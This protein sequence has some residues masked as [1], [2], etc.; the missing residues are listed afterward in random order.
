MDYP[1]KITVYCRKGSAGKTPI[2][3]NIALDRGYA[4]ATNE[5]DNILD[6]I[7][8]EERLITI[9][10]G[11][12]FPSFPAD[13]DIVFDLAGVLSREASPSIISAIEQS[14]VV[15]V[16]IYNELKCLNAGLSTIREVQPH[17]ANIV[18]VATK[19]Q[20]QKHESFSDWRASVDFKNIANVVHT[21]IDPRIEIFPLKFSKVF[22]TIFEKEKSI[23][24]LR[25][26]DML[27]KY[28]YRD[29]STQ[30]DDILKYVEEHHAS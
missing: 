13:I 25:Q 2:A 19:L 21:Q 17:N 14:N 18:V 12:R 24:Q 3:V 4:L 30:F 5:G 9:E 29:V 11:E 7:I 28:A 27:A 16:P 22:D 23:S 10:P 26:T 20:K 1:M 8:P 6:Q 15:L